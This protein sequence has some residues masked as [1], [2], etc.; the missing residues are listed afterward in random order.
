MPDL[1]L[2]LNASLAWC[3]IFICVLVAQ[4]SLTK[5]AQEPAAEVTNSEKILIQNATIPIFLSEDKTAATGQL[6]N[7]I[8][9]TNIRQVRIYSSDKQLIAEAINGSVPQ[10][11][12][13]TLMDTLPI[14]F[15]GSLAG[16]VQID[17]AI[18]AEENANS[19]FFSALL[20]SVLITLGAGLV[21]FLYQFS[22]KEFAPRLLIKQTS[23]A[24]LTPEKTTSPQS[25]GSSIL[26]YIYPIADKQLQADEQLL[27]EC[28]ASFYR[29]LEEHLRVY[30]GRI[31]SL[32]K[33]KI[34]CRMPSSQS[35]NDMQQALIFAWGMARPWVYKHEHQQHRLTVKSL[36]HKTHTAAK[37]GHLYRAITE[38]DN[39]TE[40]ILI[41]GGH[42]AYI[43][44]EMLSSL[45]STDFES[46]RIAEQQN[47]YGILRIKKSLETLWQKQESLLARP[48]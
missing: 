20:N 9:D 21:F 30:G 42:Y 1:K 19:E 10:G 35:S 2:S 32:S 43:S 7:L 31:L 22:Y 12:T 6:R 16:S 18:S 38:I 41:Q 26:L 17:I 25:I 36:L 34:I 46:I 4:T 5:S 44:A 33:D 48:E 29:R 27:Q 14:S 3:G 37:S 39:H 23:T 45:D 40:T 8:Q 13:Q 47:L 28:I 24:I 11:S 15:Q